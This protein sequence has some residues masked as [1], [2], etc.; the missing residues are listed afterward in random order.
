[1]SWGVY[2]QSLPGE[3]G[4]PPFDDSRCARS[5]MKHYTSGQCGNRAKYQEDG[6]GWCGTHAPSRVKE[7]QAKMDEKWKAGVREK[8]ARRRAAKIAQAEAVLTY[9]VAWLQTS[10]D[11]TSDVS[12]D[13]ITQIATSYVDDK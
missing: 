13:T 2:R 4:G 11:I 10:E 3:W 6:H 8:E 1:M 9:A 5:V 7:R 12:V